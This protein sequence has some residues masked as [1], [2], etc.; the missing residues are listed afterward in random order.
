[1]GRSQRSEGGEVPVA[2]TSRARV[3]LPLDVSEVQ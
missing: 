3:R 2:G 1:M